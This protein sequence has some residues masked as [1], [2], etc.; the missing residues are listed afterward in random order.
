M[1]CCSTAMDS[2]SDFSNHVLGL[3]CFSILE[4]D[5]IMS[6]DCLMCFFLG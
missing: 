5:I 1:G 4:T 6:I 3:C 2:S